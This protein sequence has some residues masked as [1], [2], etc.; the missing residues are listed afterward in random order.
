MTQNQFSQIQI[1]PRKFALSALAGALVALGVISL[2]V[3]GADN[4]NPGWPAN[5]KIRPLMVTPLAGA[6][7]GAFFYVLTR[8]R[9]ASQAARILLLLFGVFGFLVALWVGIVL[10]LDG[11][12]W[13]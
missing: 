5:W 3:F 4:P 10:G 9:P 7:G 13:D 8:L 12:M 1:E 6:A 2:F 11:T